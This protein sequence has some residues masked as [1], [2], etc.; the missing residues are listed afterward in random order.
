MATEVV[1]DGAGRVVASG[2][3]AGAATPAT[4][5]CMTYDARGRV[6]TVTTPPFG[7]DTTPRT[8]TTSYG[9][10]RTAPDDDPRVTR[11]TDPSGTLSTTVDLLGRTTS[12]TD[13]T[14]AV[15]TTTYDIAGRVTTT[16]TTAPGG[17]IST[18]GWTYLDDGRVS[19][20]SVDAVTVATVAYDAATAETTGVTYAATG[21]GSLTL[22][23][24][25]RTAAGAVKGQS[26]TI[27]GSRTLSE[28][29]TRSQAGRITRSVATDSAGVGGTVDWSY[30]FDPVGRLTQATLAAAGS[31][32]AV[33][34]GYGYAA[35]GGCGA[36]VAAGRNGSR[37]SSTV[38]IGGGL[39]KSSAYCLDAASRLTSV[40][41]TT[42]GLTI[43]PAAI[44]YDVHGNATQLGTQ[45]W[46]YDAADRV[47][48]TSTFGITPTQSLTYTR[49]PLGRVSQRTAS[50]PDSGVTRYAFTGTDDSPDI[51]LTSTGGLGEQY[52]GLPG[53]VLYRKGYAASTTVWSISN[54]HGDVTTTIT[55]T[56][57]STGFV[58]DPYG[59][60]LNATTGEVDPA[61]TPATRTG[62][63]TD[64]WHGSAQRG[65]EHLGGL[66]QMLM[67][68]RTY[69]PALGIFIAT[70]PVEGG[71][72][73]TYTYPQDPINHS[74]LDGQATSDPL[75]RGF[76]GAVAASPPMSVG[77]GSCGTV[78]AASAT[79]VAAALLMQRAL[80]R[81]EALAYTPTI[82]KAGK[83]NNM[84]NYYVYTV[85]FRWRGKANSRIAVDVW[86]YGISRVGDGWSRAG[87]GVRECERN[88]RRECWVDSVRGP[89]AGYT[90]AR[91][92]EA[93]LIGAYAAKHRHCPLGQL[94]SC[95]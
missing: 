83:S 50:G 68:A 30:V 35:T 25:A 59:Q 11:V 58:Y 54:L 26:W 85:K 52:V 36:D 20:L 94:W 51:Q 28:V 4:W 8:T 38:Q 44:G 40:T 37:T 46:S 9:D 73:T 21:A 72:T 79:A 29:L 86:K 3:R 57:I 90:Q 93:S 41:S 43:S 88:G 69:L 80:E 19:T 42:G 23:G 32:P 14:G 10:A 15:T 55:G 24:I 64:A 62:G 53:G 18:L 95:K 84:S 31:R 16:S 65:Y 27:G 77:C 48:G 89:I 82:P 1:Y 75:R 6:T 13:T 74:D 39:V 33:T 67:G 92:M 49:D 7:S 47:T 12:Y 5:T 71:N 81:A 45:T 34:L 63:T 91:I 78:L 76:G 70:D 22:G 60:P 17:G 61:A 2:H 87:V 66:N 56:T